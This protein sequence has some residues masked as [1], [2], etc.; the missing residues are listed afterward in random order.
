[1]RWRIPIVVVLALFVAV[2]CD[3]QPIAPDSEV[4]PL[5]DRATVTNEVVYLHLGRITWMDNV[6]GQ[7]P[8]D[9]L[10]FGYDPA[11]DWD[12]NGGVA[13]GGV[14]F[15]DHMVVKDDAKSD[16]DRTVAIGTMIGRAPLYLYTRASLPGSVSR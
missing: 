14:P 3:Q 16:G 6:P 11:E 7:D 5:F 10:L 2:S 12:C 13:V 9:V 15:K 4:N 8:W 1:M